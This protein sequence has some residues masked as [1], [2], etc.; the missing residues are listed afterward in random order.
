MPSVRTLFVG[1]VHGC[2]AELEALLEA[3]HWGLK[4]R[5]VLLGDL[6]AKGPDSAGVVRLARENGFLAVLGNHDAHVIKHRGSKGKE[7]EALKPEHRK[8]V[9]SLSKQDFEY[10]EGLPLFLKFPEWNLLAIHGG[11]VP[12]LPV[13]K[14]SRE[15]LL[16][17]RSITEDGEPSKRAKDGRPWGSLWKGPERVVYGHDAM[18]GL[19]RYAMATGLDTGCV[20]GGKL[21]GLVMPDDELV[22]VKA[23]EP[24][25]RADA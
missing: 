11:M 24:Y 21:T 12:G 16:N 10:L 17:M 7:L 14:Q 2:R 25:Q 5:V 3:C 20:Y 6:V 19:Q 23:A 13:E 15:H 1:D 18:R 4:D 8:A 9:T 22:S